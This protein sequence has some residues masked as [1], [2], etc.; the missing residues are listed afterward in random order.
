MKT[1]K[2]SWKKGRRA[3]AL[4]AFYPDFVIVQAETPEDAKLSAYK[5]HEHLQDV[6]VE[7]LAS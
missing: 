4:G 5:N 6:T 3:G 7:E 2:V 1:Y